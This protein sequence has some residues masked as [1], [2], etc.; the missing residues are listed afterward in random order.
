[1]KGRTEGAR[2]FT[3]SET[4]TVG[5]R[6]FVREIVRQGEAESTEEEWPEWQREVDYYTADQ[7]SPVL[8]QVAQT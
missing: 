6:G 8:A 4:G 5:M 1:M 3:W 2:D 7:I